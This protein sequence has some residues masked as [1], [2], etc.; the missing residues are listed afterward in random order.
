MA[1]RPRAGTTTWC[2]SVLSSGPLILRVAVLAAMSVVAGYVLLRPF[3]ADPG[4][5]NVGVRSS[6]P[7]LSVCRSN[8]CCPAGWWCRSS[9]SHCCW[10]VSRCRCTSCC[11]PILGSPDSVGSWPFR[12]AVDLR[13]NDDHLR[14]CAVPGVGRRHVAERDGRDRCTRVWSWLWSRWRGSWWSP[15]R[16]NAECWARSWRRRW[17][18]RR[19]RP[20]CCD[21]PDFVSVFVRDREQRIP[22]Q[23]ML[24]PPHH[25]LEDEYVNPNRVDRQHSPAPVSS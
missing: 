8:C 12:G 24:R 9:W 25:L 3:L 11:R 14:R 19:R 21:R 4:P 15:W 7:R 18:R 16:G 13:R 5:A 1:C 6:G 17:C 23:Q 22:S 10:P 2:R 20:S